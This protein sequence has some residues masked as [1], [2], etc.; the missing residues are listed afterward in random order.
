MNDIVNHTERILVKMLLTN[1][2]NDLIKESKYCSK[3]MEPEFNK[4]LIITKIDHED[5]KN[6]TK[7]WN[8]EKNM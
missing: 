8:C 5:F 4:P 3:I 2:L 7:Y 1:F 6:S